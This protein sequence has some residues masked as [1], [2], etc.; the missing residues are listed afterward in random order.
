VQAFANIDAT[1]LLVKAMGVAQDNRR[2]IANNIASADTPRY[3]PVHMDF[4]ATLRNALKAGGRNSLRSTGP[5]GLRASRSRIKLNDLVF[6]SKND[7]NK[8]D[9]DR[10]IAD[11]SQNT[12]RSGG[13][14][15]CARKRDRCNPLM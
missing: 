13:S 9:I 15:G 6:I 7:F 1:T 3:S 4:Q 11:L 12:G 10:E 14:K 8:V 5:R 2:I